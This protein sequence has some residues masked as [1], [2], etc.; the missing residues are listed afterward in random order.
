MMP[1]EAK[2]AETFENLNFTSI[3]VVMFLIQF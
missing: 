1:I 2:V 3:R